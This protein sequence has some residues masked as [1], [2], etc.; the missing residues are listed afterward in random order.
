MTDHR[1]GFNVNL[2]VEIQ[3][4]ATTNKR[5][6]LPLAKWLNWV[7][8]GTDR[9]ETALLIHAVGFD[10]T[11]W[12]RQIEA[13][14]AEYNVVAFD[15]PGHGRSPGGPQDCS[16]DKTV[17]TIAQLIETEIKQ[18]VHLIGISYGAMIAQVTVL[19]RPDL[20]RSLT[21]IGAAS[22]F[23]ESVRIGMRARAEMTRVGGMAAVL[24]S[25]LEHWFTPE[26]V[27]RRPDIIDRVS[28]SV[29]AD[30]PEVHAAIWESIADF[31][32]HD[33]LHE[34]AC[35]TLTLVGERDSST[36]PSAAAAIAKEIRGARTVVLANAAHIVT[37]EAPLKV[38]EEIGRFL[39]AIKHKF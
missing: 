10:L 11:Y 32:V 7:R 37:V 27:A 19:A 29:L 38:N 5:N 3:P 28:K 24:P 26:T 18:P 15:L 14:Q 34:I 9:A 8:T 21:L 25:S 33:R 35:P 30:D 2:F 1:S 20:I 12:D 36:P 13:L 6:A 17:A 22:T 23:Q 16:F 4:M 39:T 31:E